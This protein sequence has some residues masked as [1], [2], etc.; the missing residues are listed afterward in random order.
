LNIYNFKVA[1]APGKNFDATSAPPLLYSSSVEP[2]PHHLVK[3]GAVRR[4]GSSND[5]YHGKEFIMTQNVTVLEPEPS[6]P[7]SHHVTALTL[8]K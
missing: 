6:E 8:S 5:I 2:E 4:C 1:P 3:A 7:E